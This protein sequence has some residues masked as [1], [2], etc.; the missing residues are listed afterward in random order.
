[1]NNQPVTPRAIN[2]LESPLS[3]E[4]EHEEHWVAVSDLMG[5]LMMVFLLIAV[6]YM[7]QLEV[8]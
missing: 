7:V 3:S 2:E 8:E 4:I 5:G 6:V 1:M